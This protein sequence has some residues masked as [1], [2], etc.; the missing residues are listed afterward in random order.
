MATVQ[1]ANVLNSL[2]TNSVR[3]LFRRTGSPEPSVFK[4]VQMASIHSFYTQTGGAKGPLGVPLSN[5]EFVG[6]TAMRRYAG[7]QVAFQDGEAQGQRRAAVRVLYV[8]MK[9]L[10]ESAHDQGTGSD[11]PYF[12][13]GVV[14]TNGSR[15]RRFA[16]DKVNTK[17]VRH[18][19]ALVA[20]AG[21]QGGEDNLTPPIVLG[22]VAIEHDQGNKDEAEARVRKA[23][24]EVEKKV[25]QAAQV[26]GAFLGLPVGNHVMSEGM[27][28]IV[29]GWVPE[30]AAAV[31]GLGD[32]K[33]GENSRMLF[34][35]RA[36]IQEWRAPAVLGRHG[37]NEYNVVINVDGGKA[38]RYDLFFKIDLFDLQA[39]IRPTA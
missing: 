2:G 7:G 21:I 32:D 34:D 19:T 38:G 28:D 10:E 39:T 15:V 9:C 8:G 37:D 29:I 23:L 18:E 17:S 27:R 25:D 4:Q 11:E 16:Y 33:I 12:L 26:A 36:D 30:G 13:I 5:I 3:E 22:V 14:A 35:F 31:L 24:V 6:L 1:L 20:A